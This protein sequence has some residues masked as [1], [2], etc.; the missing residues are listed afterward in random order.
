MARAEK[1]SQFEADTKPITRANEANAAP[2]TRQKHG[3]SLDR[4]P[5]LIY[6]L[7]LI[8]QYIDLADRF[9]VRC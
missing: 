6:I 9:M 1:R 8:I 3:A 7:M 5:A 2:M 4:A